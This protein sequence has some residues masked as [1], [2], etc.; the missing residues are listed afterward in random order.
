MASGSIGDDSNGKLSSRGRV[1]WNPHIKVYT[2]RIRNKVQETVDNCGSSAATTSVAVAISTAE[3]ND[4]SPDTSTDPNNPVSTP[5]YRAKPA[6]QDASAVPIENLSSADVPVP[7]EA[8]LTTED[9]NSSQRSVHEGSACQPAELQ[10]LEDSPHPLSD[11]AQNFNKTSPI[12][13]TVELATTNGNG[14]L[15]LR[16]TSPLSS[17][18]DLLSAREVETA[19]LPIRKDLQGDGELVPVST[20][21][22][23]GEGTAD[24][25]GNAELLVI[26]SVEDR[27]K[28]HLSKAT[29]RN[30]IKE[31]RKRLECELDQVRRLSKEL[32]AKEIQISSYNTKISDSNIRDIS[33]FVSSEVGSVGGLGPEQCGRQEGVVE[34][35]LKCRF[36]ANLESRPIGL[37]RMS[38]DMG[39]ARNFEVRPYSRQL[40]VAVMENNQ[41]PGDFVEKEKRTPKANQFYRKSE[42]LLAKDRLPP[43]SNK[44]L[45]TNKG[46]KHRGDSEYAFG[47]GF[48]F[49]KRAIKSCSSLLQRLMKHNHGWVFNEPV[50]A[51]ALGL[52]DYH[53][54]IKHPMDLGTIKTRLSQKWYKSPR[55]FAEDVRL[56]FRNAMTYNP[57]GQDVHFMAEQLS[58]IFEERWQ[59][60]ETEYNPYW[61]YQMYLDAGLPTPTFRKAA[62]LSHFAPASALG[63]AATPFPALVRPYAPAPVAI[64]TPSYAPDGHT[65]TLDRRDL[66]ATPIAV[67]P[68][69]QRPFIGR[70]PAPKKPK[71]KDLN[72][73][74]MTYDEK[75]KLSTNLQSLPS[76][77]LDAIVQIIK[78]RSTALSQN[79]DEIEVDIDR[80]D[81]ETLWE[82]DRFVTNYKKSLS[83]YKRKAELARQAR[84]VA[85]QRLAPTVRA[86]MD[87]APASA[88]GQIGN[89]AD[90][91]TVPLAAEGET[92]ENSGSRSS[93]S[94]SSSSD[95]GSSSSDSDS[96]SSSSSDGSDEGNSPKT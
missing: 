75:Q 32:E 87:T 85:T 86:G 8:R 61:K 73:R 63:S 33:N 16:V 55:E 76:E 65:R 15:N 44:R 17:V 66:I 9:V 51:K 58:Q 18:N 6:I 54:I 83:K 42:F 46:R 80:V 27:I 78:R 53:D 36:I 5:S 68:I 90:K 93:S 48:G 13:S 72:K 43:E 41:R 25:N 31:L 30:E 23:S 24:A 47:F 64:P 96:D 38:S 71:A 79:D 2:R 59:I 69:I 95:S 39:V 88:D 81:T 37:A 4:V 49:D 21:V 1:Q 74:D 60:L 40:S 92:K 82:L 19:E 35:K 11:A 10:N 50:N 28:F 52:H 26:S 14:T 70:T 62:P 77:K 67:D 56:V 7:V 22:M 20:Q 12:R 84:M 34:S 91:S 94:S 45:K 89:G 29:P 57:K 3:R